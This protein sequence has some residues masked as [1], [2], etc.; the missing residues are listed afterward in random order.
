MEQKELRAWE[1]LCIQEEPPACRAGCPLNVDARSFAAAMAKGEWSSARAILEKSMPIGGIVARICEAPCEQYC[2]RKDLGGAIALSALERVCVV[3]APS[4]R[5]VFRLPPRPKRVVALGGGLSSLTVAFDL[6]KKG[7]PVTVYFGGERPGGSLN[8]FP[9]ETLPQAVV[10]DELNHLEK[11]SVA[12]K[13]IEN[14]TPDCIASA[15]SIYVGQDDI[16]P[17]TLTVPIQHPDSATFALAEPGWFTGGMHGKEH[18]YRFITNISEGRQAAI[19][20]D[21]YLQQASLTSGRA[22]LRNGKAKLYTRTDHIAAVPRKKPAAPAGYTLEEAIEEAARCINCQCLECVNHCKYLENFGAFPR[23]YARQIYNNSAI[24]KGTHMANT[25]INSCSLCRQ[26][27]EL[28]PNDFS[29]ADLCLEARQTMVREQ[30][31]PSSA[32]WFALEEMHSARTEG[33]LVRHAPGAETSDTLFYPGCQ[34][35]GIRPQQTLRLYERLLE[36]QPLTG[37]WLDCCGAPAHWAGRKEAFTEIVQQVEKVWQEMGSPRV[38]TACS[39]CLKM[40]RDHLPAVPVES[41]WRVLA[42]QA[43]V[44]GDPLHVMAIS[45]PCTARDDG[46]T[47]A[48]VRTLLKGLGRVDAPLPMSGKLTECCGFGGLM[49]CANPAQARQVAEARVAQTDAEIIT[50]CAMC[51]DQLARTGKPVS[52]ILDLLFSDLAHPAEEKPQSIS[53]RRIHRRRLKSALLNRYP[54]EQQEEKAAWEDVELIIPETVAMMMEERRILE[55]DI[56]KVLHKGANGGQH[57]VHDQSGLAIASAVLGAVTFW[58]E[59]TVEKDQYRLERCWS[60][61]MVMRREKA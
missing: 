57:F 25:L 23:V 41:V 34:L 20:I 26:C 38:V 11:L 39:T 44:D 18:R 29:M 58:V 14:F 46:D 24:V 50:Y 22:A 30:R 10:K 53:A 31:M 16:L 4:R 59:Y 51:R 1:A 12:F 54:A 27:E 35:G 48:A 6:A 60:H 47:R 7:Y 49:D 19:S 8:Y 15:D 40:F 5:K 3:N 33:S 9:E 2:I 52:H 43:A 55:D 36:L 42:E 37:I 56:R 13:P 21:R 28:C 61:R 32:H 45:D 17:E